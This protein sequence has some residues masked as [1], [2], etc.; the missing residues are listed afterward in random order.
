[1][2]VADKRAIKVCPVCM[3]PFNWRKKWRNNWPSIVYCS[4]R[5]RSQRRALARQ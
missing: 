2:P 5:C 3:R 4:A 1:M